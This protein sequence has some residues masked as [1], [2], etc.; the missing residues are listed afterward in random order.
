M[1]FGKK[2]F[3]QV[4]ANETGTARNKTVFHRETPREEEEDFPR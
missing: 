3:H 1:S 2:K 4:A